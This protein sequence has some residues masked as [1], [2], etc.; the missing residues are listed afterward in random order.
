MAALVSVLLLLAAA[1]VSQ[2][3]VFFVE[4]VVNPGF[5]PQKIGAR[6][7][8]NKVSIKEMRQKVES[9]IETTQKTAKAMK[10]QGQALNSSTIL[11]L[12]QGEVYKIDMDTRTFVQTKIPPAAKPAASQAPVQKPE[13]PQIEFQIKETGDTTRIAGVLCKRVVAQ[14]RASYVDP[15]TNQP[16]RENRYTY[17]AWIARDFPG[18]QE[19][20]AFRQLQESKTSYPPLISGGL[21]Q[22]KQTVEDYD[23]LASELQALEGF[24]MRSTIRVAVVRPGQKEGTEVFRLDRQIASLVYSSLPD[25]VFNLPATL[26]K[27]EAK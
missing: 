4:E 8:T 9:S 13:G 19:I 20:K 22:L 25:T 24:P 26:T 7:T 23:Q 3:D 17:D 16:R 1:C 6:K 18:Y 5:G 2:A 12:D 10:D 15:K 21:E 27:V 11:R 14:M